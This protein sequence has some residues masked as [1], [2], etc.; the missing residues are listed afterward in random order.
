MRLKTSRTCEEDE[1]SG[2]H[3][4]SSEVSGP[5]GTSEKS[6]SFQWFHIGVESFCK[7]DVNGRVTADSSGVQTN[8]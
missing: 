1:P 3:F 6:A 7:D 8:W 5:E 4:W 2:F